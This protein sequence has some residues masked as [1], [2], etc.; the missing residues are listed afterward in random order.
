MLKID[1]HSSNIL[2]STR[3]IILWHLKINQN[4]DHDFN[5]KIRF[6]LDNFWIK[7]PIALI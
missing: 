6:D 5:K 4:M 3:Y 7:Q 1:T 2:R